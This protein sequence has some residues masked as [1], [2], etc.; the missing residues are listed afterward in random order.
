MPASWCAF[1][2][3]RSDGPRYATTWT[4]Y[5]SPKRSWFHCWTGCGS[6]TGAITRHCQYAI[7]SAQTSVASATPRRRT[8]LGP[9][10][11]VAWQEGEEMAERTVH[12]RLVLRLERELHRILGIADLRI[13]PEEELRERGECRVQ[14]LGDRALALR[15]VDDA[16]EVRR[17]VEA[18]TDGVELLLEDLGDAREDVDVLALDGREAEATVDD[19]LGPLGDLGQLQT[20]LVDLVLVDLADTPLDRGVADDFSVETPGHALHRDVV[21]RRADA[22]RRE[23]EVVGAVEFRDRGRD[24]IELVGDGEDAP[25]GD[26][27]SPQLARQERRVGIDDLAGENLVPDDEDSGG[28]IDGRHGITP[29]WR[30]S[31]SRSRR[32]GRSRARA[33]GHRARARAR[34]GSAR[35]ARPIRRGRRAPRS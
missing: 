19:Q 21:V 27:E 7:A 2:A 25:N 9:D 15:R 32:C 35:A 18:L 5:E 30:P 23:H 12:V 13:R 4:G 11:A 17:R 22:A 3:G 34:A 31:G 10:D 29:R 20:R 8:L 26:P 6:R 24:V 33:S 14:V 16:Q 1:H 28:A